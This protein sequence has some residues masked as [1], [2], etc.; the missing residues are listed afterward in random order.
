MLNSFFDVFLFLKYP[1]LG[2][3]IAFASISFFWTKIFYSLNFKT[4][5]NI[6]RVH[7]NEVSRLGGIFIYIFMALLVWFEF[8]QQKIIVNILTS[9]IPFILISVKEDLFHDTS[10]RLRLIAMALSCLIFFYLNP[11]DFPL[12]DF[13]YL[14]HLISVYPVG[15]IF[16]TFS[17]LVV[18]NGMNLIDGMNGL[19]GLTAIFQLVS[20][21]SIGFFYGDNE[22]VV[23][24]SIFLVPLI[25]FLCFNFPLGKVFVGDTGAYFYGFVI[26]L[27]TIYTFGKHNHLLSWLAV[28]ILFYPCFE[29][30]FS[31]TRKMSS[32]LSPLTPDNKHLHTIIF[33]ELK[34][35]YNRTKFSNV[36]TTLSLFPLYSI[37]TTIVLF[38]FPQISLNIVIIALSS[39]AIGYIYIYIK[40]NNKD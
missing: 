23:V 7:K 22:V 38:L 21:A 27:L 10:P 40:L 31:F 33:N 9:A 17:L 19:F 35:K 25:V 15:I 26:A 1:L 8:I 30:L 18:M 34:N 13:P 28:L 36:I 37:P 24:S 32:G 3:L 4:Y 5:Q 12:I 29:L 11:I 2:L 20:I 6:Q 39:L 14:G 16:F